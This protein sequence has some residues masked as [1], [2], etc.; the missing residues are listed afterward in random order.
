VPVPDADRSAVQRMKAMAVRG[1]ARGLEDGVA[2]VVAAR[3]AVRLLVESKEE[4]GI[5]KRVMW[6]GSR[7]EYLIFA[8][9]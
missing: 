2:R 1:V 7:E 3:V 5:S 4:M 6:S 8:R 9:V